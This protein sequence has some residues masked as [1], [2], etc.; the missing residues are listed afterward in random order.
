[1]LRFL[2]PL[3][4]LVSLPAQA[5]E[6]RLNSASAEDFAS[7]QGVDPGTAQ[8]IVELRE[9]RG[10]LSSVEAL[11]I[12]NLPSDTLNA[13]RSSVAMDLAVT[14]E[15]GRR[16]TSVEEVLGQFKAEPEVSA[17]Q[18]MALQYS[19]THPDM[20]EGW[21]RASRSAY[22]L[23]KLNL[24]YQKDLDYGEDYDYPLDEVTGE[25]GEKTLTGADA[26]NDDTYEIKL[27]WK[28]DKLVMS[29]ERIRVISEAQDVVK[30]RDKVLDEVTRIYFDRRRLQVDLLL[31]PPA[32]LKSRLDNELRLQELTANLDALTGGRFSE[33][34]AG[35]Q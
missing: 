8:R 28:L 21:L 10:R 33:S 13:L 35:A 30:L 5:E 24:K 6:L 11:R 16:Y 18:A 9:R 17:V 34:L 20:V 23:P 2:L 27:E 31:N 26:G 4:M 7:I 32:D 15:G 22:L 1:M 29:S 14:G 19:N 3:L 25:Y 12:L